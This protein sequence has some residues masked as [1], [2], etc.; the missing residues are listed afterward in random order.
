MARMSK[1]YSDSLTKAILDVWKPGDS[2]TE[3]AQVLSDKFPKL[4]GMTVSRILK[5]H[6]KGNGDIKPSPKEKGPAYRLDKDNCSFTDIECRY[7]KE[8]FSHFI[9]NMNSK[10]SNDGLVETKYEMNE[11]GAGIL[12]KCNLIVKGK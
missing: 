11:V 8:V 3:T 7:I 1:E 9:A 12:T 6:G 10:P 5:R 2:Y 4:S